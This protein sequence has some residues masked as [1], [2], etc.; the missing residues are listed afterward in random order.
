M[1]AIVIPYYK[2]TFFE[3]TLQSLTNQTDK[4]FKVYI[5]DDASPE[6][7]R[8]LLEKYKD[9]FNFVYHRFEE[10]LGGTSLVRQWERCLALSSD[11]EWIMILGDDDALGDN[12]IASWYTNYNF[13]KRESNLVRFATKIIQ[14][15]T[16]TISSV[17]THPIWEQNSEFF[18]RNFKG[19]TRS[20]LSEYVFTRKSY[21]KYGFKDY[22]L[23]WHSDCYAWLEFPD[24][25]MIYTINEAIVFFRISKINISGIQDDLD[26][27]K[28]LKI[29]FIKDVLTKKLM[30]F[31]KYQR[32]ELLMFYEATIKKSRKLTMKEWFFLIR[33]YLINFG[34]IPFIKSIRRFLINIFNL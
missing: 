31:K 8:E 34:I 11:E 12:V 10:N 22:P 19:Q 20:S 24:G 23:A 17:Y 13:F 15:E 18:Y 33:L 4:G 25:K 29:Q 28:Q 16:N 7:P 9:Q 27:K 14:E 26:L 3:A 5:G 32:L 2:R 6:N 1:L 30:L 21:L